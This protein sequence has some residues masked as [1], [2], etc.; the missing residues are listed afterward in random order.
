MWCDVVC[1][2]VWHIHRGESG[3]ELLVVV[4]NWACDATTTALDELQSGVFRDGES[5]FC[6]YAN[7]PWKFG[8]SESA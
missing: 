4:G 6:M 1:A 2:C 5:H 7:P 8:G 3:R